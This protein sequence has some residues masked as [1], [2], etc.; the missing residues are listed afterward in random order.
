M[1]FAHTFNRTLSSENFP[2]EWQAAAIQYRQLKKCI[3]R[4]Q[5]ELLEL[6][7]TV[8]TLRTLATENKETCEKERGYA[9]KYM[10]DGMEGN[11]S[12]LFGRYF[13]VGAENHGSSRRI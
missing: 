5:L 8:E 13:F 6:G 1:K 2:E 7:L 9:V 10:F 3:K 4:V 12:L 11:K